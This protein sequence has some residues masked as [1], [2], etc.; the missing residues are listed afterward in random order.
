MVEFEREEFAALGFSS[1]V[2]FAEVSPVFLMLDGVFSLSSLLSLSISLLS[3]LLLDEPV[4]AWTSSRLVGL[5]EK[6]RIGEVEG[7]RLP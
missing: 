6:S 5:L 7:W 3:L 4:L 2:F 1:L